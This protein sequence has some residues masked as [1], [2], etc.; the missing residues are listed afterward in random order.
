MVC[1]RSLSFE[2]IS[3]YLDNNGWVGEGCEEIEGKEEVERRRM[4]KRKDLKVRLY[5]GLSHVRK[6]RRHSGRVLLSRQSTVYQGVR[7]AF[8]GWPCGR[9][10]FILNIIVSSSDTCVNAKN[11]KNNEKVAELSTPKV[12][13]IAYDFCI[14]VPFHFDGCGSYEVRLICREMRQIHTL[15]ILYSILS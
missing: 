11:A 3:W 15:S 1:G 9:I 8:N 2:C 14:V 7:Y 5:E 12:E 6:R 10:A 13:R 4:G